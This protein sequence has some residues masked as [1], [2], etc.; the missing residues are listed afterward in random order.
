[1]VDT[2]KTNDNQVT[3]SVDHPLVQTCLA[4]ASSVKVTFFEVGTKLV[5]RTECDNPKCKCRTYQTVEAARQSYS[6]KGSLTCKKCSAKVDMLVISPHGLVCR[7][8]S[9]EKTNVVH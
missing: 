6:S 4:C 3:L 1:M 8:C 5:R 7:D 2:S 9:L